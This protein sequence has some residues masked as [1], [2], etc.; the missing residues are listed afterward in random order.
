MC[1]G[2]LGLQNRVVEYI[3]LKAIA[4]KQISHCREAKDERLHI[5]RSR[6]IVDKC[7]LLPQSI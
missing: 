6:Y 5:C 1:R 7:E 4:L 3:Y 2:F